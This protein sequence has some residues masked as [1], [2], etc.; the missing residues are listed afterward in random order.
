MSAWKEL[1]LAMADDS[2]SEED[3]QEYRET[4]EMECREDE[5]Y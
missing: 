1:Q 5:D 4:W 2:V 3:L